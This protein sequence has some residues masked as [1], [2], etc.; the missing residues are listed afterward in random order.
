MDSCKDGVGLFLRMEPIT[1][2]GG[3]T[4]SHSDTGL[5]LHLRVQME[6]RKMAIMITRRLA[7]SLISL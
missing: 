2:A 6:K 4:A 5:E 7:K 1:L 3:N